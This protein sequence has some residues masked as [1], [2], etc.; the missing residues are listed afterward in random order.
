[1]LCPKEVVFGVD[2]ESQGFVGDSGGVLQ[3]ASCAGVAFELKERVER[4]G[5]KV[6]R[7]ADASGVARPCDLRRISAQLAEVIRGEGGL[8]AG[9][10]HQ[11]VQALRLRVGNTDDDRGRHSLVSVSVQQ[12]GCAERMQSLDPVRFAHDDQDRGKFRFAGNADCAGEECFSAQHD[13][14]LW[15]AETTREASSED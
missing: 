11:A 8:I 9:H 3:Q 5:W 6:C 1:M 12:G 10:Q 15:P 2:V 7:H 4:R 14:L 13:V